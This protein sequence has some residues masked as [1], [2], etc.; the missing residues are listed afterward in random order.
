MRDAHI[1]TLQTLTDCLLLAFEGAHHDGE[2]A[3]EIAQLHLDAFDLLADRSDLFDLGGN[4]SDERHHGQVHLL[5]HVRGALV[6]DPLVLVQRVPIISLHLR[7]QTAFMGFHGLIK[8][9]C[10]I[11]HVLR[12]NLAFALHSLFYLLPFF[13]DT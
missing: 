2:L 12:H 9:A 5:A 7:A 10:E 4:L 11:L 8:A 13:L 6:G 3:L 1:H